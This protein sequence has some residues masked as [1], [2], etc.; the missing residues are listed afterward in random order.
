MVT[1]PKTIH[2]TLKKSRINPVV[3]SLPPSGIRKFFDLVAG[4]PDVISLGV[5]EPDFATPWHI[6]E[7][8]INSLEL[9]HTSYSSNNG[10]PQLREEIAAYLQKQ[11]NVTYNPQDEILITVGGSEAL[12]LSFR[13]ILEP[14]DELIIVDP[15]FVSY[16]PLVTLSGGVPI[17][18][19]TT[20]ENHFLPLK[21]DLEK[22]VSP[23]TK[24]MIINYPNNPSGA[25][26]SRSQ[27]TEIAE[28]IIDSDLILISDEIYHPL[29]YDEEPLSFSS[30]PEL[31]DRLLLLHGFSKA[32][33]MTG[34]RLGF[35]AG[36]NDILSMMT[37]IHQYSIMCAP[38]TAQE[39]AIEALRH[40]DE[41]VERMKKEYDSRRRYITHHFNR[42][43]L[44][45]LLPKGAFYAFPSI[46]RS[47]LSSQVFA[48]QLLE[49]ENVAVVPGDAFGEC[50]EG[51]I[52]CSY[53]TSL[54]DLKEAIRRIE[55][56]LK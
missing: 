46:K 22:V 35:A 44:D 49:K 54:N 24:G 43:G 17:R 11:N 15:S 20:M 3:S 48:E 33:A 13:S 10:I 1:N 5:G 36:P 38:T 8:G 42:I 16:A 14:G 51:H 27:T 32:W 50:G 23:K 40:G 19:P 29:T 26:L 9:G 4:K 30:V 47:G 21:S 53:A 56:F 31:K 39:A 2:Q 37:K 25:M 55:R 6:C 7:A 28:F 34:W 52:R 45:C 18:I 12:D 41:E